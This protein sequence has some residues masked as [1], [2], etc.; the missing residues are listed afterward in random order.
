MTT[1]K[2]KRQ[3]PIGT[4]IHHRRVLETP[5]GKITWVTRPEP[6]NLLARWNNYFMAKHPR[7]PNAAPFVVSEKDLTEVNCIP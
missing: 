4:A 7:F 5:E 3:K 1:S 6:I 2:P